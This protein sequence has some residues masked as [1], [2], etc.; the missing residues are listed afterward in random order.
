MNTPFVFNARQIRSIVLL[1]LLGFGL[2]MF[3]SC[4]ED[5][6][7]PEPS[8][9]EFVFKNDTFKVTTVNVFKVLDAEET[10]FT[11]FNVNINTQRADT[12][13]YV[14]IFNINCNSTTE[15][16]LDSGTYTVS[17]TI[18]EDQINLANF[19]GVG[20]DDSDSFFEAIKGGSLKYNVNAGVGTI[21][22]NFTL[23]DGETISFVYTGE[24]NEQ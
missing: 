6:L 20:I 9:T 7:L 21:K 4:S 24:I 3:V 8:D 17:N 23:D 13:Q 5:G 19:T 1:I 2:L 14:G 10:D 16:S 11:T 12:W 18:E 22:A 15:A